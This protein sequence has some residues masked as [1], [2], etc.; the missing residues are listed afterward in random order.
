[1][2]R[3]RTVKPEFW[4]DEKIAS[5]PMPCR[6]FYIGTW[7]LADDNGVFRGNPVML[8]SKIFPYDESLRASEVQKWLDALVEARMLIP[9]INDPRIGGSVESYYIIRTFRSHQKFDARYPNYIIDCELFNTILNEKGESGDCTACARCVPDGHPTGTQH[10]TGTG[11]GNGNSIP[12]GICRDAPDAVP[13]SFKNFIAGFNDIR[14]SKFRAIEKAKRQFN[15]RL[16][17]GFTPA[18]MLQA[19]KAAMKDEYHILTGYKYLTPEFF[20][21]PDKIEK[22]IN[23]PSPGGQETAHAPKLGVGERMRPDGTRTYGSGSTTVPDDAPP[24]PSDAW[25][26]NDERKQWNM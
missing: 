14:H 12:F 23:A 13:V 19:L 17:E 21:R 3:I 6:L 8:K 5:L 9:V 15:A 16:K 2:T 11:T 26:W 20:T 24:R 4:E 22:F 18:Q 25:W 1:M 7:C 10:G